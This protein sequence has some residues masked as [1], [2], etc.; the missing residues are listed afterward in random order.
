MSWCGMRLV[1][2]VGGSQSHSSEGGASASSSLGCDRGRACA[3]GLAS[4]NL[5]CV[6]I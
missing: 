1:V 4:G 5:L 3:V 6:R 2:A